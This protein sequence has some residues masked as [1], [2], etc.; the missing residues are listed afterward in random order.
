MRTILPA[1]L[2]F[3]CHHVLAQNQI[4]SLSRALEH[5][6]VGDQ[7]HAYLLVDLAKRY[8]ELDPDTA[9]YLSQKA[10]KEITDNEWDSLSAR[11]Y[12]AI[13]TSYSFLASYDSSNYYSFQSIK[14]AELYKDTLTLIDG[15]NNLGIDFM[16]QENYVLAF[17][18][19][20][21][22]EFMSRIFG[23]SIRWGHALN[24]LGIIYNYLGKHEKELPYYE[25]SAAVFKKIGNAYGLGNAYLN[26]GTVYT[27]LEDFDR[28][29][30]FYDQALKV[31]KGLN[32]KSGVQNTLLSM[33]EN[34]L[35]AGQLAAAQTIAMDALELAREQHLVQD[36]IFALE[37]LTGITE[38][39]GDY[40]AALAFLKKEKSAKEEV[41]NSEKSKQINELQE[42]YQAEKRQAEIERLS[43]ANELKDANLAQAQTSLYGA[44]TVGIL[45][46][47]LTV[48][49]YSL[50]AKK[51][52]A[53]KE[54]QELQN[55]ALKKRFME[56]QAGP[57]ELSMELN[58][59][60]LN[61]KLN[62][63]LTE[64]EFEVFKLGVEGK[65]NTEI[66]DKLFISVNTVK[67]HLRNSYSK[68]GVSNRKEAFQQIVKIV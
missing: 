16:Y 40:E 21:K 44:I 66:A 51:M 12:L 10:H 22:V 62:T 5:F 13:A 24:N 23:D 60:E 4:D 6:E 68:M 28:A 39:R 46:V 9:L 42:K 41:F 27:E 45:L 55:E 38:E 15:L 56:L 26:I 25:Q 17:D 58:M 43:L 19:F 20:K 53:E 30:E 57:S 18:Y 63:P 48:V 34:K 37:L 49:F 7:E 52:K 35:A 61:Y 59:V 14:K 50:R 2:L 67:F 65:S 3:F 36:E 33:S 47:V 11:S 54:A 31:Y 32:S 1:F 29:D 8:A 64:R